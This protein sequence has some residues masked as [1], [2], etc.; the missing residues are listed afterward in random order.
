MEATLSEHVTTVAQLTMQELQGYAQARHAEHRIGLP[1]DEAVRQVNEELA[2]F[3]GVGAWLAYCSCGWK[4]NNPYP[5]E[6]AA[7]GGVKEHRAHL[8]IVPEEVPT[9]G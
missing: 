4:G 6:E 8:E 7:Q 1:E 9:D 5:G 2:D 3:D